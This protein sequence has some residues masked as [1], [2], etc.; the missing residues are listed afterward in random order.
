MNVGEFEKIFPG[1]AIVFIDGFPYWW[2]VLLIFLLTAVMEN[3]V[4]IAPG[5][6]LPGIIGIPGGALFIA[7]E[8][9]RWACVAILR[10]IEE[11]IRVR[12]QTDTN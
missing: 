8:G 11:L 9:L 4:R 3:V 12:Q 10:D 1:Q 7:V 2:Q 5:F 6:C